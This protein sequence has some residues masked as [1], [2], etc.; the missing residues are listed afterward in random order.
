MN[1]EG[2]EGVLREVEP[3]GGGEQEP[4]HR[5]R[6]ERSERARGAPPRPWNAQSAVHQSGQQAEKRH[7]GLAAGDRAVDA[8]GEHDVAPSPR[9]LADGPFHSVQEQ[10][11]PGR[12]RAEL[13][14]GEV[15]LEVAAGK[16]RRR[17]HD[18]RLS[19]HPDELEIEEQEQRGEPP[20]HQPHDVPPL[21]R[22]EE[23]QQVD[24]VQ[25]R[26]QVVG[27]ERLAQPLIGIPERKDAAQQGPR[28]EEV[29]REPRVRG[30]PRIERGEPI[31]ARTDV[32]VRRQEHSEGRRDRQEGASAHD[33]GAVRGQQHR[34]EQDGRLPAPGDFGHVP[35]ASGVDRRRSDRARA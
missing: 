1:G 26:R 11:P 8:D 33:D 35:A 9:G 4:D 32:S 16:D 25:H 31:R 28:L 27:E 30:A 12:R 10:G 6:N 2:R 34:R 20:V 18:R 17:A 3:G 23:V 19:R 22:Q 14:Q 7:F 29:V 24:R 21:A 5:S 13:P 15:R